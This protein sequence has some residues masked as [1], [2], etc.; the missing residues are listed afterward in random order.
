[1]HR[2]VRAARSTGRKAEEED[3]RTRGWTVEGKGVILRFSSKNN[4][5]NLLL[6][7]VMQSLEYLVYII[8]ME[9]AHSRH[10][11]TSD[12]NPREIG[13][14]RGKLTPKLSA[15]NHELAN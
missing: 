4:L 14:R 12:L 7:G 5:R 8:W 6:T 1:M 13:E 9:K 2:R 15:E 10:C 11:T 3:N